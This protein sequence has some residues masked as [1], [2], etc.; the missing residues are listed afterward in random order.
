MSA[1]LLLGG[2]AESG[3]DPLWWL[4]L[5]VAIGFLFVIAYIVG[6]IKP[7]GPWMR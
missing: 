3:A 5:L 7:G 2:E 1:L 4:W 6:R